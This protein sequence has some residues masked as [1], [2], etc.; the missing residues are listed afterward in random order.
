[1]TVTR[2]DRL[3]VVF[4]A[5]LRAECAIRRHL[6]RG[7]RD[8]RKRHARSPGNVMSS[9]IPPAPRDRPT[10]DVDARAG[11]NA[12]AAAPFLAG[13]AFTVSVTL[14]A[15]AGH[16]PHRRPAATGQTLGSPPAIVTGWPEGTTDLIARLGAAAI[17]IEEEE[18]RERLEAERLAAARRAGDAGVARAGDRAPASCDGVDWVVPVW[19]VARES[20]CRVDAVSPDGRYVGA[21]QFDARHWDAGSGWG[22]CADLGDWRDP[23]SQHECARRLSAGGT[24]LRPW[25]G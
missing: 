8:P 24:D 19:I 7:G 22:G 3:W 18:E 15:V 21:Y 2:R 25:G 16:P 13:L 10:R 12:S 9:L 14:L 6:R 4:L 11:A 20:G 5:A 23:E 17:H 1:M